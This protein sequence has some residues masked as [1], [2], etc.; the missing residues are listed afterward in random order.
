MVRAIKYAT[1]CLPTPLNNVAWQMIPTFDKSVLGSTLAYSDVSG[2]SFQLSQERFHPNTIFD[3][4]MVPPSNLSTIP[5]V[6]SKYA[7]FLTKD[8]G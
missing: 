3:L 2:L 4:L 5:D 1:T 8:F 6:L 7:K